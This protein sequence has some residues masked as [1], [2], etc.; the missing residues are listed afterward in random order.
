MEQMPPTPSTPAI[1]ACPRCSFPVAAASAGP[2]RLC[3]RCLWA[4]NLL[5]EDPD[6]FLSAFDPVGLS[7]LAAT[8]TVS[9]PA[10]LIAGYELLEE[11]ARGGMGVVYR[12]RHIAL[13]RVIALKVL[14][15]GPFASPEFTCRFRSEAE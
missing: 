4:S 3:P 9:T 7:D 11:I 5:Q 15:G 1:S 10:R 8:A 13:N 12:A 6:P 2:G 14:A